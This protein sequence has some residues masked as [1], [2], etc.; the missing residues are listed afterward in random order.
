MGY[1]HYWVFKKKPKGQAA[2]IES[3][4]QTALRQCQR[5]LRYH[6]KKLKAIDQKNPERLSG[7][8]VHTKVGLYGGLNFNGVGDLSHETFSVREYYSENLDSPIQSGF[9]FCKTA[10]KPYDIAVTACLIVLKHYLGDLIEVS[11]DGDSSD[12]VDGLGLAREV[13][14]IKGLVNPISD[15]ESQTA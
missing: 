10:Q 11:S 9:N 15:R 2:K 7:Y 8:S 6:N 14:K 5:V 1:T 13:T 4:Y 12:W 3:Q